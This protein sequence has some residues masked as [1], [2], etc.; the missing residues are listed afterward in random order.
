MGLIFCLFSK[1]K[2]YLFLNSWQFG[3]I[4]TEGSLKLKSL[5]FELAIDDLYFNVGLG[6]M[7]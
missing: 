1:K 3:E 4:I 5:N 2:L 6:T 7:K